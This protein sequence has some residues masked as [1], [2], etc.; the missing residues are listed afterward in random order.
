MVHRHFAVIGT[1]GGDGGPDS[2]DISSRGHT[3]GGRNGSRRGGRSEGSITHTGDPTATGG[4][5]GTTMC[6]EAFR[7]AEADGSDGTQMER[8]SW[9]WIRPW[10]AAGVF[11]LCFLDQNCGRVLKIV[12]TTTSKQANKEAPRLCSHRGGRERA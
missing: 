7:D 12:H 4:E 5:D 8:P 3:S 10:P 9:C 1:L 2:G 6:E 11:F